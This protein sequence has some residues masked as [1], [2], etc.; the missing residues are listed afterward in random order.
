[1]IKTAILILL[2]WRRTPEGFS[3][4]MADY[5][6]VRLKDRRVDGV[7]SLSSDCMLALSQLAYRRAKRGTDNEPRFI[8]YVRELDAVAKSVE[9]HLVGHEV[10][11]ENVR[12]I[13]AWYASGVACAESVKDHANPI[14]AA[15]ELH[16]EERDLCEA[17][18]PSL[19]VVVGYLFMSFAVLAIFLAVV[20][21]FRRS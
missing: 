20:S 4:R 19:C 3:H 21:V 13:L 9:A 16:R 1:M 6:R 5:V 2:G 17:E 18:G 7:E 14:E 11:D 8:H 12:G 15:D 10:A